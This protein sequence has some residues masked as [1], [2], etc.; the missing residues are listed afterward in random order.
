MALKELQARL[1]SV[2]A[3]THTLLQVAKPDDRQ[4]SQLDSLLEEGEGLKAQIDRA[5]RA[6]ALKEYG[7]QSAGS[8]PLVS[9]KAS[10]VGMKESGGVEVSADEEAISVSDDSEM[11]MHVKTWELIRSPEYGR[12]FKSYLRRGL[13][14]LQ[15]SELKVLQEGS[16]TQGGFLV[17]EDILNR[18]IAKEPTPVSIAGRV[19]KITTSRDALVIPRVN[20]TTDNLYTTGIRVTWTGEVP[21]SATAHRVTEP[22]FGQLR[23]PIYTAMLSLP[24]TNNMVEDSLFPIVSWCSDKFSETIDLLYDNMILNGSGAAQPSGILRSPGG[25]N[26]PGTT[27]SGAAAALTADGVINL[28]FA[29]PPQYDKNA[30]FCFNKTSTALAIAKLKDGDGRYL[31]GA[32]LQDSGMAVPILKGRLLLGYDVCLSE[33]M[34]NVAASAYP[35]IFGDLTGYYLVNRIGFSIQVLRELY[36][37]TNQILLLGRIRFGGAVAEDWKLRVQTVSV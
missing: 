25:T 21:A 7:G 14:G 34:P 10:L 16:D 33:F 17:P 2:L 29:L 23:I 24:L 18:V 8:L 3:E 22:V 5:V 31:W 9:G 12:A 13:N 11:L 20:Y 26:E 32:G 28:A 4:S 1:K 37:E 27:V 19:T 6:E 15:G 36:A 30:C 35:I